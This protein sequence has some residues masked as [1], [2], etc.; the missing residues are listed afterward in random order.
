MDAGFA[1][2]KD[3][4]RGDTIKGTFCICESRDEGNQTAH[5]SAV[6][7]NELTKSLSLFLLTN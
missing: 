2:D 1:R 6:T 4:V 7:L 5:R 3:S